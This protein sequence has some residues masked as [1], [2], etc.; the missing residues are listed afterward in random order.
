MTIGIIDSG[1][2]GYSIY[3]A[4]HQAYPQASF[5]F[6]ADQAHAPYGNKQAQEII[7]IASRNMAWFLSQDITE[8]VIACNTMNA[9]ALDSLKLNFPKMTFHDVLGPTLKQLAST[10]ITDWLVVAT[11]LTI[12]SQMYPKAMH[13]L[14]PEYQVMSIALP[15]LVSLIE[16]L[17]ETSEV[18]AY[19]KA[20]LSSESTRQSGLILG[21][22]HYPLAMESFQ[23]V[24][25]GQIVDSIQA[26][27]KH[28]EDVHLK[29]G[30]SQCYT[31]KDAS[32]AHHQVRQ[33]FD[34]SVA[35]E[36]AMVD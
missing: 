10:R 6:L 13:T 19:L 7:E 22:T 27:V 5:V 23:E 12:N 31:T 33:L 1:L 29:A 28:F 34:V 15:R 25:K 11:Q 8:V 18:N 4:L 20:N 24:F 3:H 36:K 21:C 26:M 17:A 30:P 14:Y 35:F 16:G 2:G 9:V 32:Y